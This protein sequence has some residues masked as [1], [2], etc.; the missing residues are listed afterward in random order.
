M[1]PLTK[2]EEFNNQVLSSNGLKIVRF[3]A[4][5]SGPCHIIQPIFKE[6]HTLYKDSATFYQV[7]I[8]KAPELKKYF[9][10]TELPT[11]LIFDRAVIID[12]SIGMISRRSL[13]EKLERVI[14]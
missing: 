8:D 14:H 5:W 13:M 2:V 10:V 4:E 12:F 11:I 1:I 7:D 6:M 9:G 3:C